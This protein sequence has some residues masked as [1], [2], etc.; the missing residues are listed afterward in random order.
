M[1]VAP[2]AHI[3]NTGDTVAA[4]RYEHVERRVQSEGVDAA[5]VAVVVTNDLVCLEIP[6]LDH[7]VLAAREEV[8]VARRHGKTANGADVT[9]ECQP[10]RARSQVPDLDG[11]VTSAASEPLVVRLDGQAAHPTQ[12]ARNDPHQLPRR[13]PFGLGLLEGCRSP[14]REAHILRRALRPSCRRCTTLGARRTFKKLHGWPCWR[15]GLG[16]LLP[17]LLCRKLGGN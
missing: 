2:G 10:Q 8:W 7:L 15:A 17:W 4:T 16:D 9:S 11:S 3:P 13:V 14:R 6:A 5:E 12:M 1:D